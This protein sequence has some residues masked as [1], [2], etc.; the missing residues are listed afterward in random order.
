MAIYHLFN[1]IGCQI[2]MALLIKSHSPRLRT[3]TGPAANGFLVPG[4]LRLSGM[5]KLFYR[6][7]VFGLG[8]TH[9]YTYMQAIEV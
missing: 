1:T 9:I 4:C 3:A 8:H 5:S 6:S 2:E 7:Y